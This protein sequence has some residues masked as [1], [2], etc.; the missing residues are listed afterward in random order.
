MDK[1]PKLLN[2]TSTT[3]LELP[4]D[5]EYEECHLTVQAFYNQTLFSSESKVTFIPYTDSTST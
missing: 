3:S 5:D 4:L 1:K 2:S